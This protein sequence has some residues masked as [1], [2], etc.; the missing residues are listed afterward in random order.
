MRADQLPD[1]AARVLGRIVEIN[2]HK[3]GHVDGMQRVRG[4]MAICRPGGR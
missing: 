1:F 3:F 4:W 2:K